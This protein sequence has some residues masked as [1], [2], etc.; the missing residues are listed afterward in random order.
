MSVSVELEKRI[1]RREA[2]MPANLSRS[3]RYGAP[4]MLCLCLHCSEFSVSN[5]VARPQIDGART[6]LQRQLPTVEIPGRISREL[7][8]RG[9]VLPAEAEIVELATPSR[10]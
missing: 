4:P 7:R 8:K 2:L 6:Y 5:V 3:T 1:Q 9:A 10:K